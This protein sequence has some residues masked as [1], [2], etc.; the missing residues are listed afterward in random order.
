MAASTDGIR[1]NLAALSSHHSLAG[2][3]VVITGASRGIG[4]A[5]GIAAAAR[6]ANVAILAKSVTEDPRIPGT[7][8]SAKAEVERAGG[9]ALAVP[10]DIRFEDNVLSA[11][12]SVVDAFGGVDVLINNA[13]AISPT[14]TEA[15]TMKKFDLMHGVNARGT[16]LVSKAALPHLRA[17]AARGRSPH[18]LNISPPLD[19]DRDWFGPHVAYTMAKFGMSMCTLGM[20]AELEGEVACNALWPLTAIATA[21]VANVLG[22]DDSIR[23]SRLPEMM[24]DAAMRI[25]ESDSRTC[26]GNFYIDE[27]VLKASGVRDM[28]RYQVDRSLPASELMP[29]FFIP[30]ARL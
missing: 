18:I 13:S 17:S 27:D 3:T 28:T 7:I 29:D 8:Y 12:Q 30:R 20:S 21:A 5:L 25:L 26:S 19:M 14:P 10:C 22:G 1:Q 4:L 11:I 15:T 6:G 24:A 23:R 9:R 16:F 2:Y